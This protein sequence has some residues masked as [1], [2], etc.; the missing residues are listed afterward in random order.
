MP[1]SIQGFDAILARTKGKGVDYRSTPHGSVDMKI[2][3]SN[4]G[5]SIYWEVP[6]GV[7]WEILTVSYARQPS[8][9][10]HKNCE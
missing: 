10:S 1:K 5:R 8:K 7:V 6:E 2:N 9:T 4:G 3:R